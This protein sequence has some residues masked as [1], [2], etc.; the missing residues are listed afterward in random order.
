MPDFI[1]FNFNIYVTDDY[2][3][4]ILKD[5]SD[6]CIITMIIDG[7]NYSGSYISV[8][9]EKNSTIGG[10]RRYL[11]SNDERRRI[12]RVIKDRKETE[13]ILRRRIKIITFNHQN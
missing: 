8:R 10:P 6:S 4:N 1:K 7:Y 2:F 12:I 11:L 9:E 5:L 13:D 3:D